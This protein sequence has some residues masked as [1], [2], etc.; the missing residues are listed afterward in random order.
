[1]RKKGLKS[2]NGREDKKGGICTQNNEGNHISKC[3][4]LGPYM[5]FVP[6]CLDGESLSELLV[7]L[8]Y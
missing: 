3:S 6:H 7:G 1:M 2:E 4:C 5:D 8:F